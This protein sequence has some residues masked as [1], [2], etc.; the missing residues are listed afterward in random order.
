MVVFI[1]CT[2]LFQTKQISIYGSAHAIYGT[3][4]V[5][6]KYFVCVYLSISICV[7]LRG[8]QSGFL[9]GICDVL[10]WDWVFW[11]GFGMETKYILF[12]LKNFSTSS[13]LYDHSF[14]NQGNPYSF[15]WKHQSKY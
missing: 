7:V 1:Q 6:H 2:G 8:G 9:V 15:V 13:L 5:Y 10:V 12:G 3:L 11:S 14:F 4:L